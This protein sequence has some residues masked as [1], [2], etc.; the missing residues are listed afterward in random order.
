MELG[1]RVLFPID[2][3]NIYKD[4]VTY[5][6]KDEKDY[7]KEQA[8]EIEK[9]YDTLEK[10]FFPQLQGIQDPKLTIDSYNKFMLYYNNRNCVINPTLADE[11]CENFKKKVAAQQVSAAAGGKMKKGG[12]DPP[13]FKTN[14]KKF[15]KT[16]LSCINSDPNQVVPFSYP[17]PNSN[18]QQLTQISNTQRPTIA[19]ED[20]NK[21]IEIY[22][23]VNPLNQDDN[24]ILPV[25][26]IQ[27]DGK[28]DF[29]NPIINTSI[30]RVYNLSNEITIEEHLSIAKVLETQRIFK[31]DGYVFASQIPLFEGNKQRYVLTFRRK[32]GNTMYYKHLFSEIP[33]ILP[34]TSEKKIYIVSGE[35]KANFITGNTYLVYSINEQEDENDNND[36]K[37]TIDKENEKMVITFINNTGITLLDYKTEFKG[38]GGSSKEYV[39]ILGRKR[40]VKKQG[41]TKYITYKGELIKLSEAKKLAK[42]K[43]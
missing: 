26:I 1:L 30:D 39:S 2:S 23:F 3:L 21:N 5:L 31:L 42:N 27:P 41:R 19:W 29:G 6:D 36:Y 38:V 4:L 33:I 18:A 7:E 16:I 11:V 14:L 17:T 35:G 25:V 24:Y 13:P 9:A 8:Y 32:E 10:K 34:S 15:L 40:L 43:K 28:V 20:T 12:A 22:A 37:L